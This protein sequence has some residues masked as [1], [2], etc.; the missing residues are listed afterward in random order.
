MKTKMEIAR[1][2][3]RAAIRNGTAIGW[4]QMSIRQCFSGQWD[5]E[6]YADFNCDACGTR[7]ERKI[8]HVPGTPLALT[9]LGCRC[10]G[11]VVHYLNDPAPTNTRQW[12]RS[13]QRL[14]RSR[15]DVLILNLNPSDQGTL[16]S[17]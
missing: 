17:N 15:S 1:E 9:F 11:A 4:P 3:C 12:R 8:K 10:P 6:G 13:L 16:G 5:F 14:R 2:D 7:V